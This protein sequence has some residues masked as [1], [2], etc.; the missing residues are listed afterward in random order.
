VSLPYVEIWT[1]GSGTSAG[2]P[3]GW[4]YVMELVRGA[5]P[6]VRKE[7]FGGAVDGTN[8]RAELSAP[9]HALKALKRP[10]RV[11]IHTDSEYVAN[12]FRQNWI[13]KWKRRKWVKV[14]NADLW[15]AL[16]KEVQRHDVQWAWVRG[17]DGNV[18]NERCDQLAGTARRAIID[19]M[20]LGTME[21]LEFGLDDAELHE[22]LEII[23]SPSTAL[24]TDDGYG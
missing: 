17:H 20:E 1:D 16:I 8:N 6:R 4:A 18:N 22:Q 14:K 9:L 10:C 15:Q 5:G 2:N 12:A 21:L 13:G 11:V 7:G 23:P 3:M 19:C 24:R